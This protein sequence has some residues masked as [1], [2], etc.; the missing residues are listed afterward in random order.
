[1][2]LMRSH[3]F[4]TFIAL[5]A[6]A[7]CACG[8]DRHHFNI[9]GRFL[10]MNQGDFYVYSPDGL[11]NGIDTIHVHGGRFSYEIACENE[12]AI[13]IVLPNFSEIPIFVK[14]GKSVDMKADAS[15]IKDIEI[16][17][18][19]D[20]EKMTEWRKSIDG[21]TPPD[22]QKQ[23]ENFIRA[24][25]SSIVSHWL[26]RKY[27]MLQLNPNLKKAKELL[28]LINKENKPSA[29]LSH[30]T[31]GI[32]RMTPMQIGDKMPSFTA[33]DINGKTVNSSDYTQGKAVIVIWASWN[34][35]GINLQRMLRSSIKTAEKNGKPATKILSIA[36][37]PSKKI[38]KETLKRDS[39]SWHVVCDEM[40]WD[41]PLVKKLGI[42]TVPD[43]I[44]L[45]NGVVIA[46]HLSMSELTKE[47]EK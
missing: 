40:L 13:V 37:D 39:M 19:E 8:P 45:S 41:S 31:Q 46:R 43:N 14:P 47:V 7:L 20:N 9:D 10:K 5:L 2:K 27:F 38:T 21:M 16:T 11:I 34:Y 6:L 32:E 42:N 23:A 24:N 28:D 18:T 1:M 35:D 3:F 26:L 30:L 4:A 17:G 22:Q 36:F 15:H 44:V 25:P 29:S 33:I 12:G